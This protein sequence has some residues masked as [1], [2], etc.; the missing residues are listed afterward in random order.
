[1][2]PSEAVVKRFEAQWVEPPLRLEQSSL[3]RILGCRVLTA[4][5][6][7]AFACA[8][9]LLGVALVLAWRLDRAAPPQITVLDPVIERF[10]PDY[11]VY[12]L[13][14]AANG[15]EIAPC[16]LVVY[17]E[18]GKWNVRCWGAL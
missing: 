2:K 15:A 18:T 6:Q 8:F 7:A 4:W 16:H 11:S 14:F 3:R 5:Q 10:E 13:R 17:G 12:R 9:A 1:M